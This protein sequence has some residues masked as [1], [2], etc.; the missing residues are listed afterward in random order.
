MYK[1]GKDILVG[2]YLIILN[3]GSYVFYYE[4]I[5][6]SIGNVDS[7]FLNDIFSGIRY[8]ILKNG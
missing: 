3:L 7:I 4:V 5:S 2:E 8:I 1:V 6:D